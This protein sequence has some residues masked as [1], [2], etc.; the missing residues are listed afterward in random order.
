MQKRKESTST[1]NVRILR[2]SY[3]DIE[4]AIEK[5]Q[6]QPVR[7]YRSGSGSGRLWQPVGQAAAGQAAQDDRTFRLG[8]TT[9]Q[10]TLYRLPGEEFEALVAGSRDQF[11]RDPDISRL[12]ALLET[13]EDEAG[14]AI[15][16]PTLVDVL[17]SLTLPSCVW[18][19]GATRLVEQGSEWLLSLGFDTG[20]HR[21]GLGKRVGVG[22][23]VG[24]NPL[25]TTAVGDHILVTQGPDEDQTRQMNRFGSEVAEV[26]EYLLARRE[27]DL[28]TEE[29]V[30]CADYV[31]VEALTL[32]NLREKAS[33]RRF[34]SRAREAAVL[35]W[36]QAWLP[37][38]LRDAG[39]PFIRVDPAYT[40][41]Q[42]QCGS[43]ATAR[44]TNRLRC[45]ACGWV[46]DANENA[47]L[48][49]RRLGQRRLR[50]AS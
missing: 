43:Y 25:A 15:A 45:R 2:A 6:L 35:D 20:G 16:E 23:D 31:A 19:P 9:L 41:Q 12:L 4:R 28:L 14:K 27:L 11:R 7:G 46:G 30:R 17:S 47:A 26:V 21:R 48:N 18:Q 24:L 1:Y 50:W 49:I 40:S 38:R 37:Q 36:H 34:V 10:A 8:C 22:V 32:N 5:R 13:R 3:A 29:L 39:I 33:F 44:Q 42:C